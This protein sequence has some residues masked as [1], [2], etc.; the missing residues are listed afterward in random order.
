MID[1]LQQGTI[2]AVFELTVL[3]NTGAIVNLSSAST[4]QILFRKP[5]KTTVTKDAAFTTNGTDGKLRYTTTSEDDLD[6]AG[7]WQMQ[8]YVVT[9][10]VTGHTQI[11]SFTVLRNL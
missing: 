11:V 9:P 6:K 8:A 5:S 7:A 10:T 2:G 1:T 4:K 3:D